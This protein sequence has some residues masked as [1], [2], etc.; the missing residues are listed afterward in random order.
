MVQLTLL[1]DNFT[2]QN[3]TLTHIQFSIMMIYDTGVLVLET[4]RE[5]QIHICG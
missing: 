4:H 1:L 3:Y 5:K 2:T